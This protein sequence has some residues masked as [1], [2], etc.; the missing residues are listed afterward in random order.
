MRGGASDLYGSS[1]IGGVINMQVA[2]PGATAAEL[3][4][5]YGGEGTHQEDLLLQTRR[6]PWG[7]LLAGSVVG[8]DG[9]IQEAPWQRGPV[10]VASNVHAQNGLLLL[11]RDRGPLRL[12]AR[13]TG[14]NE[15]RSNGTPLQKNGTRLW[16]YAAGADLQNAQGAALGLR[17]YGSTEHYNQTF[18]SV[19]SSPDFG[20]P[21]CT[22]RCGETVTKFAGI[23]ANELG[24]A[25]HG[26][27]P[28]SPGLLLLAGS[29]VHDVRVWD[30]E[31]TYA[32]GTLT[33]LH[34]HQRDTGAYAEL[35]WV[36][37]AWMIAGSGRV[38]WFQ[39]LGTKGLQCSSQ[40]LLIHS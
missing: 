18:S 11:E 7:A 37:K 8:T 2:H 21:N 34:V 6:A 16:R 23:A 33:N 15:E 40:Y 12:F 27:K 5:S 17:I 39:N 3:R 4:S 24:A 25:L 28:L 26:S 13:G 35:M 9:Y 14:F 19:S 30:L 20:D 22:F 1:A 38:D 36:H 31:N 29:D 10:D 32:T